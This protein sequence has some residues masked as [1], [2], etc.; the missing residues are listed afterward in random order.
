MM[1]MDD[2]DDDDDDDDADDAKTHLNLTKLESTV[3]A[4]QNPL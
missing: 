3:F 2:D 1:M 4:S